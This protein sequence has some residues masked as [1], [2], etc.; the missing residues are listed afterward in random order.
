MNMEKD[1]TQNLDINNDAIKLFHA[2]SH[3]TRLS[4][5][6]A[7]MKN[8]QTVSQ[9]CDVLKLKQYMV[10]QQLSVLRSA[11]VVRNERRSRHVIYSLASPQISNVI[12]MACKANLQDHA[13]SNE[14]QKA[15]KELSS[16]A[17][18]L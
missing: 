2:L 7:L 17:R 4:I 11:G 16:F 6:M 12:H 9:L 13:A 10:S 18:I 1:T 3:L 15:S 14:P 5:C 8:P